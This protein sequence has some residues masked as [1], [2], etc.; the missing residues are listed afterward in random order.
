MEPKYVNLKYLNE[1]SGGNKEL[2]LEMIQIFKSEVPGYI[3]LMNEFYEK[4]KWE[5]LGKLS[6]KARASASIMGMKQLAD[7]LKS[8][9]L[10][11][12][13]KKDTQLYISFLR[14]IENQFLA[15]ID[16]LELH[17]KNL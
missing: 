17:A 7:E 1:I 16:E 2:I 12:Q 9:E 6:H 3:K 15:A 5:A 11:A 4:G 8:L 13:E 14:S 10:L